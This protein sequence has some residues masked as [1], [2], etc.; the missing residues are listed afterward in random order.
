MTKHYP[1]TCKFC[2]IELSVEINDDYLLLR[3]GTGTL[4]P[5]IPD[6]TRLAAC[7]RCADYQ[8]AKERIREGMARVARI[9]GVENYARRGNSPAADAAKQ[10]MR[11]LF[12]KWFSVVC[13]FYLLETQRDASFVS[14]ITERPE[15]WAQSFASYEQGVRGMADQLRQ[16]PAL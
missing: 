16:S 5:G 11:V 6:L 10:T 7:N 12:E 3:N 8:N 14:M 1:A 4:L 2:R 13:D 9:V 15:K